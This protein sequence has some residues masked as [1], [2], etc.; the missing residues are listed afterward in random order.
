MA[1]ALAEQMRMPDIETLHFEERLGL[2][3][4]RE[5]AKRDNRRLSSRLRGAKFK[6]NAVLT[7]RKPA[8]ASFATLLESERYEC[9]TGDQALDS[10][11]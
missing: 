7:Q 1:T 10:E 6:H 4:D 5:A 3:V 11:A 8:H 2:L 9:R